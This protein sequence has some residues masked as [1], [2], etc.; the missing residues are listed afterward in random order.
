MFNKYFFIINPAAGKGKKLSFLPELESF[1]R[2]NDLEFELALTKNSGQATELA[3][4]AAEKYE[5]VVAVG[6][7]GTVNEVASG[8][9][10]SRAALGILPAG[11][12]NDFAWQIGLKR[13]LK[14][15]L[16]TLIRGR[17]RNIDVGLVND[18]YYFINA[19][20]VGFDAAV[21][22]RVRKYFN[23]SS[24]FFGYLLCALKTLITYRQP[25]AEIKLDDHSPIKKEILL[26]AVCNGTTYGG[27]FRVAPA[28][29][30]DDGLFTVCFSDKI[31]RSRALK[32]LPKFMRGRHTNLP[33]IHMSTAKRVII[34]SGQNNLSAQIDGEILPSGGSFT[35]EIIPGRLAVICP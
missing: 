26:I 20:S 35:A 3:K 28:A 6:G 13:N 33:F 12:G 5:A 4:K 15:D 11:S 17:I 8:L 27:G 32:N 10:G 2:K 19:F 16:E 18:K 7:D 25:E 1:C 30:M 21:A 31:S 34:K 22:G 23:I 9:I 14:S 24:G 29:K